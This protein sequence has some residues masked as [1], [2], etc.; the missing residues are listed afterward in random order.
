MR[1]PLSI[2]R[3]VPHWL[4]MDLFPVNPVLASSSQPVAGFLFVLLWA[5]SLVF[6]GLRSYLALSALLSEYYQPDSLF[7]LTSVP[8]LC[9]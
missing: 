7:V 5:F 4:C 2:V 8:Q 6:S 1:P 3:V 9:L